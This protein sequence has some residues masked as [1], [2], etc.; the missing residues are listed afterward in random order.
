MSGESNI[1]FWR[2]NDWTMVYKDG[3]LVR[4]GDHYLADEWL[5][6]EVGVTVVD[7]EA[8]VC[9]PD[10]HIAITNLSEVMERV[11]QREDRNKAAQQLRE[12]AEGL[13][14]E[15]QKLEAQK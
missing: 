13:L 15:A 4:S 2:S 7:D 6:A 10:G 5:Q 9:I 1:Q 11:R 3:V 8:G 12:K 14:A